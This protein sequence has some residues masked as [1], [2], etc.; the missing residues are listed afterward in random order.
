MGSARRHLVARDFA[1]VVHA[2]FGGTRELHR[3]ER[4]RGGTQKGVYRL[5]FGDRTTGLAQI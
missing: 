5:V 3:V 4:L 1:A 2:A